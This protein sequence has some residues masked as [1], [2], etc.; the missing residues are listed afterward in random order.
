MDLGKFKIHRL[1][2]EVSTH[3]VIQE[4]VIVF[5]DDSLNLLGKFLTLV[6][7]NLDDLIS[8][9]KEVFNQREVRDWF[10]NSYWV[11]NDAEFDGTGHK[12]GEMAVL[13]NIEFRPHAYYQIDEQNIVLV[14]RENLSIVPIFFPITEFIDILE[15]W[16]SQINLI[17]TGQIQLETVSE[18]NRS[19][20]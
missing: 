4:F 13:V 20:K 15:W 8:K 5:Q 1:L 19:L 10:E 14:D 16:R 9:I 2:W 18:L 7:P 12:F 6:S 3:R 17:N 11:F